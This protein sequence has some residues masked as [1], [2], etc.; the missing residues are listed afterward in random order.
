ML[1]CLV[2]SGCANFHARGPG[3]S[4]D[5]LAGTARQLRSSERN[6]SAFGFSNKAKQ[7]EEDFGYR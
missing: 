1:L 3:F 6:G 2:L 5:E 7:I 4:G